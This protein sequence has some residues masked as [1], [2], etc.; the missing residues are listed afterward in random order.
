MEN[1][2][3]VGVEGTPA[4]SP[5]NRLLHPIVVRGGRGMML[6]AQHLPTFNSRGII[7]LFSFTP[8]KYVTSFLKICKVAAPFYIYIIGCSLI[9]KE[10]IY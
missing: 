9:K 6:R 1:R 7:F 4:T 3:R 8:K 5:A 2:Q 10:W